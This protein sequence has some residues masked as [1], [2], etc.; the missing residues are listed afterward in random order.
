MVKQNTINKTPWINID[1]ITFNDFGEK[2]YY[3]VNRKSYTHAKIKEDAESFRKMK[4]GK[5]GNS[6]PDGGR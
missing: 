4:Q 1:H 3:A 5:H 2:V 6:L